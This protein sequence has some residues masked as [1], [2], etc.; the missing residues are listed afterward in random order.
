MKTSNTLLRS[1]LL[2]SLLV[3]L[4]ACEGDHHEAQPD[5]A[6]HGHAHD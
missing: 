3:L 4:T 1:M 2:I 5:N 6:G